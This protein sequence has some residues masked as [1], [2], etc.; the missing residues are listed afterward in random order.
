MPVSSRGE[1][2]DGDHD[3]AAPVGE[4]AAHTQEGAE[5][6][7]SKPPV[8][9]HIYGPINPEAVVGELAVTRSEDGKF[10]SIEGLC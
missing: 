4:K 10:L 7:D 3:A 1:I 8:F 9:P 2:T 5:G 6:G